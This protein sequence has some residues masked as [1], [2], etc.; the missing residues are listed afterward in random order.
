[1][2]VKL[3]ASYKNLY[4]EYPFLSPLY[5]APKRIALSKPMT[6]TGISGVY[7]FFTGEANVNM[8]FPDY[9][10]AFTAAHEMAHQRGIAPEDGA[11]FMAFVACYNSGDSFLKYCSLVE[12]AN[13]LS[14]T[15]YYENRELFEMAAAHF[16]EGVVEEYK[17]YS[18]GYAPYSDNMINDVAD[19]VN[20]T[21]LKSQGQAEG[22]GSYGLVTTLA[23]AYIL[24]K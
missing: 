6:Y 13:F 23:T 1:M 12:I 7:T 15:L 11:N 18:E 21:Y 5:V 14:N 9:S 3:N 17:Q 8:N 19:N 20:D 16:T 2:S 24:Q 22:T 10:V 4:K